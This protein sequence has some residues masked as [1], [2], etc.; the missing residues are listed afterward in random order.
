M[1]SYQKVFHEV[2]LEEGEAVE[3]AAPLFG[4]EVDRACEAIADC[5]GKLIVI[6]IGK[7]GHVGSKIAATFASTGTPSFF[8]HAAEAAHGDLGM[9]EKKDVVLFLSNSGETSEVVKLLAPIKMLGCRTLAIT[10]SRDSTLAK[11]VDIS[12]IYSY[13]QEADPLNLAPTVS[14]TLTLAV[15]DALAIAV[16]VQKGF[17][18][19]DFHRSHPGGALGKSLEGQK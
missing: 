15:G 5:R 14:S 10:R 11:G 19:E 16:S 17:S 3:K 12:L 4:S 13:G 7:S 9:I 6:G 18:R 1:E 8:L 2:L